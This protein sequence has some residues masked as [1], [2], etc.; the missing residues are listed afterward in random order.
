MS[1]EVQTGIIE[2]PP[3]HPSKK[4]NLPR[5]L[6]KDYVGNIHCLVGGGGGG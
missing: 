4:E 3:L 1:D 6:K 2:C 5:C